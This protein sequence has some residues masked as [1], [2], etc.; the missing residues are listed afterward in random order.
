MPRRLLL[1]RHAKAGDAPV[2]AERPLTGRGERQA[3]AIGSW[4]AESGLV[5]DAAVVSPARRAA[6]TWEHA[7]ARL[8]APPEPVA[9]PRIYVNTVEAVLAA[10]RETD[11]DVQTLAVVGH[12][13]SI[14]QLAY[15]LDDGE[16]DPEARRALEQGFPTA[17]VAVFTL[18]TPFGEI[19]PGTATLTA[20]R[21]F[22]D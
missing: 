20:F 16:G 17:A 18:A 1:V 4:L 6:Q 19:A 11:D 21:A 15:D 12:N 14:G 13:P 22:R 3:T 7:A 9:E 2:D 5:P 8:G 10:V